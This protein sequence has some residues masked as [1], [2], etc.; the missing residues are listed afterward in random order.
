MGEHGEPDVTRLLA[1]GMPPQG[2]P[3]AE[4]LTLVYEQLR[5][6]AQ[7]RMNEE[8]RDHTLSA[9]A[10]VHEAYVKLVGNDDVRWDGK[11]H[12]FAAAAEAMRLILIDHARKRNALKRAGRPLCLSGVADLA[13]DQKIDQAVSLDDAIFR[14]ESE[15]ARAA[16][17]VRLRF[18]AGLSIDD[19]AKALAV[20]PRTVKRDWEFARAWLADALGSENTQ[21]GE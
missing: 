7:N 3:S 11:A 1:D 16:Q 20:N 10:L 4:L 9:T 18:Y 13:S 17:V 2:R 19:T 6:I 8:R 15:D 5:K 14:L 21:P 12:F